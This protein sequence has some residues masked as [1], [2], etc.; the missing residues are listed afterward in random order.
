MFNVSLIF[1][2]LNILFFIYI[3]VYNHTYYITDHSGNV[4][5]DMIYFY[6]GIYI[7]MNIGYLLTLKLNK[8]YLLKFKYFFVIIILLINVFVLS[9]MSSFFLKIYYLEYNYLLDGQIRWFYTY[10]NTYFINKIFSTKE[11]MD[12]MNQYWLQLNLVNDCGH[13]IDDSNIQIC[14]SKDKLFDIKIYL[15]NLYEYH[16]NNPNPVE[17]YNPY[18]WYCDIWNKYV[19]TY[20]ERFMLFMFFISFFRTGRSEHMPTVFEVFELLTKKFFDKS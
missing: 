5:V 3:K 20:S 15:N 10:D 19:I 12:F 2:I 4:V 7:L 9:G 17:I 1:F 16:L 8:A 13:M 18:K 11:K 14:L 6:V